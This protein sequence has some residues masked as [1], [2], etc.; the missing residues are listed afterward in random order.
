MSAELPRTF[1]LV[2]GAWHGA[3]CWQR[4]KPLLEARG[5]LVLTPELAGTGGSTADP[6]SATLELWARDIAKLCAAHPS[7]VTLLGHS[8]AGAVISRAAELAPENLRRL[9]FLAAYL[10]PAGAQIAV[11]ARADPDS[12]V[13]ANMVPS[14]EGVTCTLRPEVVREAFHGD[15]DEATAAWASRQ[16]TAEPLKPL[17]T[18]LKVTGE[19]FGRVPRAYIECARD[20]TIGLAAQRRMQTAWACDVVLT[21]DSAHSPFLSRP[22]E[23]AELLC[24]L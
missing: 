21:L 4:L 8:R 20:R 1:V 23:L 11:E 15:C 12:L 2:P 13:A 9:V 22:A 16:L 14:R 3:W 10:L 24:G 18:P 5:A 6:A 17:V 19:R 7:P